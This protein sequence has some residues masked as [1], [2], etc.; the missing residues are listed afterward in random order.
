MLALMRNHKGGI[1]W[2]CKEAL[3]IRDEFEIALTM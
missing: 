1:K 3:L 2:R